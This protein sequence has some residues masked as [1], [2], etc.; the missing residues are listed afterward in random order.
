MDGNKAEENK[1]VRISKRTEETIART[2][3]LSDTAVQQS[4]LAKCQCRRAPNEGELTTL[5][6]VF[7][8][9]RR[10]PRGNVHRTNK[11]TSVHTLECARRPH[12]VDTKISGNGA[13][14]DSRVYQVDGA[15]VLTVRQGP[16]LRGISATVLTR[17]GDDGMREGCKGGKAGR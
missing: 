14:D 4:V 5:Q 9:A 6:R 13:K 16:T 11:S 8:G 1:V 7:V 17:G 2:D 3:L 12:P 10:A 15:T